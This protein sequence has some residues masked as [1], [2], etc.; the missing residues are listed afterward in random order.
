MPKTAEFHSKNEA[1]KPVD[2]RVYHNN[3]ACA[4]GVDIPEKERLQGK[5]RLVDEVAAGVPSRKGVAIT[6]EYHLCEECARLNA[7][8]V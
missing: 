5:G 8:G 4:R 1:A 3:S 6:P 7:Q 2:E